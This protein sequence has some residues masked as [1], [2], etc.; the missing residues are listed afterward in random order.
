MSKGLCDPDKLH[1]L[2]NGVLIADCSFDRKDSNKILSYRVHQKMVA[3]F[4]Q[5]WYILKKT[6]N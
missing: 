6:Q 3:H 1:G 4:L 2:D 5:M